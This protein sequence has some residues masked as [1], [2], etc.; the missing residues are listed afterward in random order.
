MIV[1]NAKIVQMGYVVAPGTFDAALDHWVT[2]M[3]AGP[4]YTMTSHLAGQTFRGKPTDMAARVAL[5]YCG[6]AQIELI[7]QTND[8][9][10][11]YTE[12]LAMHPA[13]PKAGIFHHVLLEVDDYDAAYARL[14]A[15]GCRQAFD[16]T[17]SS[18]GRV[19][20]LEAFDTVGGYVEMIETD[21]WQNL[22]DALQAARR[23]WDGTN[24]VRGMDSLPMAR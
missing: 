9:A 1:P 16:A 11:P 14:L 13:V 17:S 10:G 4:F 18:G 12:W 7:E 19:A 22:C 23:D 20:Y 6:D 15:A 24:P 21:F 2:V 3:G 8:A 5:G